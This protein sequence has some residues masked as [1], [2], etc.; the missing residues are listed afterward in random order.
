MK[1]DDL[2]KMSIDSINVLYNDFLVQERQMEAQVFV[3]ANEIL[4]DD[5]EENM[6]M[7]NELL[8]DLTPQLELIKDQIKYIIKY[9]SMNNITLNNYQMKI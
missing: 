6:V 4:I 2:D 1:I 5:S 8:N 9:C 3:A 7:L